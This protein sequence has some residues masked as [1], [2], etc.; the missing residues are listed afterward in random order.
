MGP[1][2]DYLC[3]E[4]RYHFRRPPAAYVLHNTVL[5]PAVHSSRS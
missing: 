4:V 1:A 3:A 2:S 5:L